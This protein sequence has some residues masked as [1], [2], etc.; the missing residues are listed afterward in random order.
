MRL[1][2]LF[3]FLASAPASA[4]SIERIDPPNWWVGMQAE[5]VQLLIVGDNL[6]RAQISVD[7]PGVEQGQ[8]TRFASSSY[9]AVE[10]VIGADA[11]AGDVTI[12]LTR[13]ESELEFTYSLLAR[14][15]GAADR[16]G[17][18]PQ[19]V[20]YLVQP[21]R[22]ANGDPSN[23][24]LDGYVDGLNREDPGGRHGGDIAGLIENLPYI[25]DMG[26]TQLWLNPLQENAEDRNSYHGY[27]ITDSYAVDP[28]YG[29]LEEYIAL[30]EAL[31]DSR[32]GLIMDVVPNHFGSNHYLNQTRPAR[33]FFNGS[34]R[35][36]NHRQS[37]IHDP[38]A[39]T[40]DRDSFEDGWFAPTMPDI[41]Q[42]NEVAARYLIQN[43]IWW[44]ETVGI[45]G[46]RIDTYAFS[47]PDFMID[48]TRAIQAEYPNL[49]MVGEVWSLDPVLT[50]GF[51]RGSPI[52]P[53]PDA[54]PNSVMDFPLLYTLIDALKEEDS[55]DTGLARLYN[56]LG[57]DR[58][59]VDPLEL[60]TFADNHDFD[61]IHT[62]LNEETA[63][64]KMA[65]SLIMTLR[66]TPQILYG[67][68][69]LATNETPGDHGQ[70]R[71]DFPGGFEGDTLNAFTGE[72]L[73]AE[74]AD[75]LSFV[76]T[77][78][79]WRS[80]SDVAAYGDT[81]HYVPEEAHGHGVYVF[82]RIL[83]DEA[84]MVIVNKTDAPVYLNRTDYRELLNRTEIATH[85]LTGD[86]VDLSRDIPAE[87]R[88]VTILE[89]LR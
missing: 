70:I 31:A 42:Q 33:D 29:T 59:Y 43:A 54:G 75:M 38:Y 76:Q 27:A 79:R 18:T 57:S 5:R 40:R 88:A 73:S 19:D 51:Q 44:I 65:L 55:W 50:A 53:V 22:F 49:S 89:F 81:I 67:T 8:I 21:D 82:G 68:E 45:T 87:A 69:I 13:E 58:L 83:D 23:D 11:Q 3:A 9:L 85:A 41:N 17:F 78:A 61:R 71:S 2:V 46:L 32:M 12:T 6:D 26:F 20:V 24:T 56:L 72:G 80:T 7:Y 34:Y 39:S 63:L 62:Q 10:L 37:T 47:D 16:Q 4:Q 84:I 14:E 66:G 30:A 28:R 60:M 1:L 86:R 77:L 35:S 52:N 36:T 48:Y 74:Q 64:T 25:A 15:A